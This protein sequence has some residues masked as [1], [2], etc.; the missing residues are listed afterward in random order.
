MLE[1]PV[2]QQMDRATNTQNTDQ[3]D[4]FY[5]IHPFT[6]LVAAGSGFGKTYWVK[7]LLAEKERLIQPKLN[8][9][10]W[11]YAQWQPLYEKIKEM[12]PSIE[13]VEGLPLNLGAGFFDSNTTNLMIVDDMMTDIS[14][15]NRLT[16]LYSRGSHHECC[17]K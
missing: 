11:C 4:S 14:K 3:V 12:D 6:M 16:H 8:R 5:F 2:K 10:V 7:R 1:H 9:I 13:F 17:G 15:D